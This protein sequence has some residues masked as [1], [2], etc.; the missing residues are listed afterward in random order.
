MAL[1]EIEVVTAAAEGNVGFIC[2]IP[3]LM[4]VVGLKSGPTGRAVLVCVWLKAK[5]TPLI[6]I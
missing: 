1:G 4:A 5:K 6:N 3:W 2:A